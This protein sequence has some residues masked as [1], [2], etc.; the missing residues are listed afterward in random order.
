ML[1]LLDLVGEIRNFEFIV[2]SS[3]TES[4]IA[5]VKS[6]KAISTTLQYIA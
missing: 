6:D 2:T 4:F 3:E 5:R 1:K